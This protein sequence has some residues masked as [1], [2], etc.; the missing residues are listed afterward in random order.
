MRRDRAAACVALCLLAAPVSAE[1]V[2]SLGVGARTLDI[3]PSAI[4]E[5]EIS[6]SG[7]IT[8]V[9]L[10]LMPGAAEDLARLTGEAAGRTMTLSVCGVTL[11]EAV[12]QERIGSGTVYLAGTTMIRAEAMRALWH[13]R[14]SCDTLGPE[15]FE[16]GQ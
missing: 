13:G 6:E 4:A 16:Y 9:F 7:G 1:A 2:L 3:P 15:V 5:M 12:V 14:A 11:M 8:D 10:R